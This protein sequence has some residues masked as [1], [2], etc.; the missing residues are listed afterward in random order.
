MMLINNRKIVSTS[1]EQTDQTK[2]LTGN[3]EEFLIAKNGIANEKL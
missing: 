3:I 2:H 1:T